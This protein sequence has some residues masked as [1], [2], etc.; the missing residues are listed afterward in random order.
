M[1]YMQ[2]ILSAW[3]WNIS[4][5]LGSR[6]WAFT[7]DTQTFPLCTYC[8]RYDTSSFPRLSCSSSS[9]AAA[10]E[11]VQILTLDLV[12]EGH[13]GNAISSRVYT[14]YQGGHYI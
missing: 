14:Q 2:A 9:F 1:P 12:L 4:F 6:Q 7:C 13:D 5:V 8:H 3:L 10:R 11:P